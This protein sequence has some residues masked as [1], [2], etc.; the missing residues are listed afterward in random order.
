[1]KPPDTPDLDISAAEFWRCY[2]SK[3]EQKLEEV[4]R[5]MVA[6][7]V[8]A[9]FEA[10]L[11]GRVF[12]NCKRPRPAWLKKIGLNINQDRIHRIDW[13]QRRNERDLGVWPGPVSPE[14]RVRER[15]GRILRDSNNPLTSAAMEGELTQLDFAIAIIRDLRLE[16]QRGERASPRVVADYFRDLWREL[17]VIP[18]RDRRRH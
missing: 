13:K 12:D 9:V 10:L 14:G 3:I 17:V 16:G 2:G 8:N 11:L 1:M 5:R 15:V 18:R 4:R 6:G 7:D